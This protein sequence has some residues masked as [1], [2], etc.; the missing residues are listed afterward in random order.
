[1]HS[2]NF[3]LYPFQSLFEM[4]TGHR[5][6]LSFFYLYY[7]YNNAVVHVFIK[8]LK[9]SLRDDAYAQQMQSPV[10]GEKELPVKDAFTS[11]KMFDHT[12]YITLSIY[13]N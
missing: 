3:I 11:S 10:D 1:M 4:F 12:T 7:A 2:Y 6:F 9:E 5:S 8:N 13:T